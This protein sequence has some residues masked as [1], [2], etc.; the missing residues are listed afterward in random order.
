MPK[1]SLL[2]LG[3]MVREKRAARKLR[4]V[5]REIDIS[6]P[7]LMRVEAGRIPDVATFGKLCAW[8]AVDPG[9]FLGTPKSA[10]HITDEPP[11]RV[12]AHFKADKL[13]RPQTASA[14]AKMLLF[15]ARRQAAGT[16]EIDDGDS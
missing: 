5:A 10:Q 15:V 11:V 8:L 7:T 6:A 14:L 3:R 2:S 12:S 4:E 9:D 16:L 1:H 13:P